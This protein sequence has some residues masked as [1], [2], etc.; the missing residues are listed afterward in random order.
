MPARIGAADICMSKR[1]NA[2]D[3]GTFFAGKA[4]N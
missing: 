2:E 4:D 1:N 3:L